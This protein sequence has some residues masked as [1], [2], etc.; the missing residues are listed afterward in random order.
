MLSVTVEIHPRL[1]KFDCYIDSRLVYK[2]AS[3]KSHCSVL[4]LT[5]TYRHS[6]QSAAV[7]WPA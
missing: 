5:R 1:T 7:W 3:R 6:Y 4:T 2:F